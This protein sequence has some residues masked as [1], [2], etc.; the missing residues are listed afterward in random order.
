MLLSRRPPASRLPW[1]L[2]PLH[3]LAPALVV[4]ATLLAYSNSFSGPFVFDDV[5]AIRANTSIRNLSALSAVLS[6][7][8][9]SG[10][11]VNGR[12][13]LNLSLA[14]NYAIGGHAVAG[15]HITNLIIHLGAALVLFGLGRRLIAIWRDVPT[16]S[17]DATLGGLAIAALW[18]LHP[19]QTQAVTYIVQR[20]ESLVGLFFLL[21]LYCFTRSQES[22]R[23]RLWLS[24]SVACCL[25]GVASKEVIAAAP[26]LVLLCDR[27]FYA[28]SFRNAWQRRRPYYVFLFATW[29]PLALQILAARG[30]GG[31]VG[32][33][34]GGVTW[35]QYALTQ[36]DA[37]TRYLCSTV[38]PTKLV[39]DYGTGV[40]GG[41]SEVWPQFAFIV[42]L[43]VLTALALWRRPPL[44]FLGAWFFLI[45]APSSS[46]VPIVTETMAEH[47]MYLPLAALAAI[48][49]VGLLRLPGRLGDYALALAVVGLGWLTW[50]RN[51]DYK[52]EFGLWH[53][54]VAHYPQSAR[55]QNNLGEFLAR[56][57]HYDEAI[58]HYA[59]AVRI[60]PKYL[61]ALCNL[62]STLHR[63]G[64]TAEGMSILTQLLAANPNHAAVHST[65]GAALYRDG[66]FAEARTHFEKAIELSPTHPD[67]NNNLGVLLNDAGQPAEAIRHYEVA[68][69]YNPEYGDALYN[70]GNALAKLGNLDGAAAKF[71]QSLTVDPTRAE[72]H[73]NLG[74]LAVQK[75][76]IPEATGYFEQAVKYSPDYADA[77][78]NLG[79]MWLNQGKTTPAITLFEKALRLRPDYADAR[80]NLDAARAPAK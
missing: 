35:W 47:R 50:H 21:T 46:V 2:P 22:P 9:E 31:T 34:I 16:D 36:A 23:T 5:G 66:R 15:Y 48:A 42:T 14:V 39:F 11:T 76:R 55:A 49:A 53:S 37:L 62:G 71:I 74:A 57:R 12:P 72:A 3:L 29:L 59:E 68:L 27:T 78:N 17:V 28:H 60:Q 63:V 70:Y 19:L 45:L 32:F 56:Q 67:A 25:L 54:S 4:V 58:T 7:P 79:V 73:N 40:V 80:R 10:T 64:Q 51:N 41:L 8:N 77:L 1:F 13:L 69:A 6:P 33:G 20:A 26:L 52:T 43:V 24:A 44:G 65:Y 61:D 30:R 75:G 18:S 38:W